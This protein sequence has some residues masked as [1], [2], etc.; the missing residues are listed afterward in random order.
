MSNSELE[1]IRKKGGAAS[2][3]MVRRTYHHQLIVAKHQLIFREIPC[4]KHVE[5]DA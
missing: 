4:S 1:S 3:Y 2:D 5:I